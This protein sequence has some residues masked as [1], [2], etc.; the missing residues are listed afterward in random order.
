MAERVT[1]KVETRKFGCGCGC[2]WAGIDRKWREV[3]QTEGF[4]VV[5]VIVDGPPSALSF[6]VSGPAGQAHQGGRAHRA[7]T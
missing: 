6:F 4:N 3:G 7:A 1:P 5:Q 2:G